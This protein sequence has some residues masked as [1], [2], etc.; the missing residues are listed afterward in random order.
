YLIDHPEVWPQMGRAGR[1]RVEQTYNINQLNHELMEIYQQ[2]LNSE[3][4]QSPTSAPSITPPV[5]KLTSNMN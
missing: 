1:T 2:L 3:R 4:P 5:P